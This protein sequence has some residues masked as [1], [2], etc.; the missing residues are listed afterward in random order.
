MAQAVRGG[1]ARQGALAAGLVTAESLDEMG[2]AWDEWAEKDEASLGMMHG[3]VLI[4]T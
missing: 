2:K 1:P 4:Q 3:E